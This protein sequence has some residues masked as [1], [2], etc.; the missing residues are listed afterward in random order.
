MSSVSDTF[1]DSEVF[2]KTQ[3][4]R[5]VHQSERSYTLTPNPNS[6]KDRS[7]TCKHFAVVQKIMIRENFVVTHRAIFFVKR[8]SPIIKRQFFINH[9]DQKLLLRGVLQL[10]AFH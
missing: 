5:M 1:S 7:L 10:I 8:K 3:I 6:N 2:G 4:L 9:F